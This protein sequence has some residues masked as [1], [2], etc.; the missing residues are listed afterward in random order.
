MPKLIVNGGSALHPA[1]V[2]WLDSEAY[3][4]ALLAH[5]GVDWLDVTAIMAW[6][7]QTHALLRSDVVTLPVLSVVNT[8]IARNP[9]IL[10]LMQASK[11]ALAPL[12]AVL[13]SAALREL[14][15]S[16]VNALRSCFG[17][18]VLALV[19]PSPQAWAADIYRRAFGDEAVPEFG[20]DEVDLTALYMA[21][22]LRCFGAAGVDVLLLTDAEREPILSDTIITC[23]QAVLNVA[24]QYNWEIGLHMPFV[25]P[26]VCSA[27]ALA[28]FQFVVS[29]A[30]V[31]DTVWVQELH[32]DYW[33][34]A[35]ATFQKS[36]TAQLCFTRIAP[37]AA[38]TEVLQRIQG[39][40]G[41]AL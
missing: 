3:A 23:Y 38:P 12:K 11:C 18:K 8:I 36:E 39:I 31:F 40:T 19:C 7:R 26:C 35:Y 9:S 13:A 30:P 28:R 34:G 2:L 37:E 14:C 29:S 24:R 20:E 16:L 10:P 21:D 6:Y 22:F 27:Q 17:N 25:W 4:G 33:H 5:S 1:P 41:M 15:V 32:S